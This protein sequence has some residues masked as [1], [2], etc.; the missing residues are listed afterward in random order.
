MGG[1]RSGRSADCV[2]HAGLI[3]FA[4]NPD[5]TTRIDIRLTYN[6]V[7][8]GLGHLIAG[9]FGADPKSEI[10]ADLVRMKTMLES[11]VRPQD[12]AHESAAMG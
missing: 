5:G 7:A 10:D 9:L 1:G 8:G 4:S 3:R 6:P 12:G 11:G 2:A